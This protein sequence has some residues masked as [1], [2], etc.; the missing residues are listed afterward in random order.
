LTQNDFTV[1]VG[2]IALTSN[3]VTGNMLSTEYTDNS[4]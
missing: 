4:F 2:Y 1:L 3:L